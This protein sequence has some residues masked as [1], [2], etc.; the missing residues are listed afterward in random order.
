MVQCVVVSTTAS[1]A[2][3]PASDD[4]DDDDAAWVQVAQGL[5]NES[6]FVGPPPLAWW[7]LTG[8]TEALDG[9]LSERRLALLLNKNYYYWLPVVGLNEFNDG[10]Y[11]TSN[12]TEPP[13]S[14]NLPY[15]V[16]DE[17]RVGGGG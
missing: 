15:L 14:L 8:T 17:L 3:A 13:P 11:R 1:F 16:G 2:A 12:E 5:I 4:D 9:I 7:L 6:S 10:I